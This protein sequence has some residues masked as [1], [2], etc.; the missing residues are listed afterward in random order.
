MS[1]IGE[2][3]RNR[4]KELKLTLNNVYEITGISIGNLSDVE[5]GKYVPSSTNLT[6]LSEVLMCSSD[7]I[8]TG[9]ETSETEK[10]QLYETE[11]SDIKRDSTNEDDV[12]SK[13]GNTIKMIQSLSEDLMK[14]VERLIKDQYIRDNEKLEMA[15]VAAVLRDPDKL[16]ELLKGDET[17]SKLEEEIIT[18]LSE[19]Q[20]ENILQK[21]NNDHASSNTNEGEP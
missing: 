7:W 17:R 2:R 6:K 11:E 5:R 8:L 9:A 10:S 16:K 15:I 12:L 3:I 1:S 20:I 21:Y 18:G 13:V 4:R 19:T 14:Q